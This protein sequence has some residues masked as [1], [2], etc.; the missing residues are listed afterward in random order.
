MQFKWIKF[1]DIFQTG[2]LK[3]NQSLYEQS[4]EQFEKALIINKNDFLVNFWLL[5]VH[6]KLGTI[7]EADIYA[8]KCV[9][10]RPDLKELINYWQMS[11]K[12]HYL[13]KENWIQL[14]DEVDKKIMEYER[15][16]QYSGKDIVK[17]I[18]I[19]LAVLF[20]GIFFFFL[21]C[22]ALNIPILSIFAQ[23]PSSG[24]IYRNILLIPFIFFYYHKPILIT[25]FWIK[26][27]DVAKLFSN[28]KFL[29]W[30]TLLLTIK[31]LVG[32]LTLSHNSIIRDKVVFLLPEVIIVAVF[33]APICEE[34]IFRGL[35]FKC[36]KQFSKSFAYL[37]SALLFYAYHG[38]EANYF[39]FILG[40]V[41]A[42]AYEE[43]G[44]LTAPIVLHSLQ[45]VVLPFFVILYHKILPVFF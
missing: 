10:L 19:M 14:E 6:T 11:T 12:D 45:N 26:I 5:R 40:L 4:K 44:T 1:G 3:Y 34:V 29:N 13:L 16:R 2:V 18:L 25:N 43:F 33:L 30:L 38:I 20:L 36:V 41:F 35:L 32:I 37:I 22:R 39:H 15:N 9:A 28:K 17:V 24:L 8:S 31:I 27:K 42:Y 23:S 21:I 7:I